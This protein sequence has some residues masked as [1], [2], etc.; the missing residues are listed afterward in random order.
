MTAKRTY[1]QRAIML[2]DGYITTAEAAEAMGVNVSTV[3][4]WV[5]TGQI[6]GTRVGRSWYVRT[7]DLIE[8]YASSPTIQQRLRELQNREPED[9]DDDEEEDEEA[10]E[11]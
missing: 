9:F 4:R 8:R 7:E 5:K 3:Y 1:K 10:A 2:Q 11:E 6:V